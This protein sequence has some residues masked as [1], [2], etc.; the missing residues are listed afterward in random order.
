MLW[1]YAVK[2]SELYNAVRKEENSE[3]AIC[4]KQEE[5][6]FF[7]DIKC[8]YSVNTNDDVWLHMDFLL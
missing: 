3:R 7:P 4:K 2:R 8:I 5:K 6:T 1:Q